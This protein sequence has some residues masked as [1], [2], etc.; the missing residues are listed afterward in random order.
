M[1][2]TYDNGD[3]EV[4]TE[5]GTFQVDIVQYKP[6]SEEII[7]QLTTPIYVTTENKSYTAQFTPEEDID[8]EVIF[9]LDNPLVS[10]YTMSIMLSD[11]SLCNGTITEQLAKLEMKS[12]KTN[13]EVG[14]KVNNEDFTG[15][16]I[17][18]QIR[19]I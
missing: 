6:G 11:V 17:I 9:A 5:G 18:L 12:N 13:L 2:N 10:D 8:V 7:K 15:A 16:N 14:K 3:L 1:F 4:D 19:F